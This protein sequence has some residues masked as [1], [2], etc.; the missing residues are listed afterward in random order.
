MAF[1]LTAVRGSDSLVLTSTPYS[2]LR[3]TGMGGAGVRRVTTQG[4]NQHGD[5][6]KGFRLLPRSL[7]LAIGIRASTDA[8]L[9][10]YRDDL[11]AIFKPLTDTPVQLQVTRDDA[12]VRVL[13]CY[14]R[15][16]I[17][18]DLV[19]EHR[20]G[21]YHVATVLLYAPE[22]AYYGVA[23]GTATVTG[24]VNFAANWWLAGG[25]IG[26]AQVLMHGGTPGSAEAWS[27]TGTVSFD[28]G[29]TLAMR[30]GSVNPS[31]SPPAY[32]FQGSPGLS[33]VHHS[34][35]RLTGTVGL[36][37]G[38][39]IY[40][41][42]NIPSLN[43]MSAGTQNY[44][45]VNESGSEGDTLW[46]HPGG[47]IIDPSRSSLA[48]TAMRWRTNGWTGAIPL[49]ALYSPPLS[50]AQEAALSNY[51]AGT[52]GSVSQFVNVSYAGN[53]PEYPVIN[54]RG[55]I[56]SPR[57]INHAT[58]DTLDFGTISISAGVTYVIDTRPEYKTV[59]SG[60]VS[61]LG[62]LTASSDLATW[63]LVPDPAAT[64]GI[65]PIAMYGTGT[66]TATRIQIVYYNRFSSL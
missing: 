48:G 50:S 29:Y 62:E 47:T 13:D 59:T 20:P 41:L 53:L 40:R 30:A 27:Y 22:A 26:T 4:P 60:T 36:Y 6:D 39:P 56:V 15:G 34:F 44:F 54:L 31:G 57:I 11:M 17:R 21:H 45:L 14:V 12:T 61:K 9:D 33:W 2:L 66:G 28:Q 49:Y 25:A 65:N 52:A 43:G 5:T 35:S 24:T 32:M 1:A 37:D 51:M 55:P 8:L 3:A 19:K 46:K 10:G 38:T 16:E 23:P 63:S 7:E 58:G 18:I 42:N 64:D